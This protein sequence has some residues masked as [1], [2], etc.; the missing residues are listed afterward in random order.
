MSNLESKVALITGAGSGI[1]RESAIRMSTDGAAIM[2]ADLDIAS[3]T[4]TANVINQQG[5]RAEALELDVSVEASFKAAIQ[6]TAS[7]FG[8]LQI[9][10]NNA[11]IGGGGAGWDKTI[12]INLSG[13]YY[14]LFHGATFLADHGGGCIIN[15][16]SVAGLVGLTGPHMDN[17]EIQEGAGAYV[18]SKHGVAGLT[19]QY[20]VT[21]ARRGVRVNAIAPGYIET[22]M[23]AGARE[24]PG[25]VQYLESLHPIGRLGQP[26]EI[27]AAASFLASDD[28]SFITGVILP[29]DG[30]YTAR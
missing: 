18:A 11:G 16:T 6:D 2:C 13:V 15:T 1:G 19:K 24:V 21:F 30:G 26:Q 17:A 7:K 28:A 14:G 10:F 3:A 22:P 4:N 23:T 9:I 5:G 29:V 25:A 20:A 27:A 12:A 8:G